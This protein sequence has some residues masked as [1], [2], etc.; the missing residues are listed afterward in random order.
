MGGRFGG[1]Q[2]GKGLR[3]GEVHLAG[4][5]S[6]PRELAGLRQAKP[7]ITAQFVEYAGDGRPAAMDVQLRHILAGEGRRRRKP[8]HQPMIQDLAGSGSLETSPIRQRE[9]WVSGQ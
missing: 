1:D 6:P 9:E 7:R 8:Q 4:I 2:I 5:E 3:R